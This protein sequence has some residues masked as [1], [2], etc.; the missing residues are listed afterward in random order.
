MVLLCFRLSLIVGPRPIFGYL[1][2]SM[3]L[4]SFLVVLLCFR[5]F[6]IVG[7]RPIFAY[8]M[9]SYGFLWFSYGFATFPIDFNRRPLARSSVN[10]WFHGFPLVLLCFWLI[11]IV[12]PRPIFAYF[13]IFHGSVWCSYG[14]AIFPVD[15]NRL[16]SPDLRL[17]HYFPLFYHGFLM[18]LVD[19]NRRPSPDLWLSFDFPW[20]CMVFLW[21]CYISGWL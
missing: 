7:P 10:L 20:I 8:L 18:F 2:F 14:L 6:W 3:V 5:L 12:G 9:N 17:S 19:F 15:C 4:Y 11:L 21:S 1:L 13:M 16:P